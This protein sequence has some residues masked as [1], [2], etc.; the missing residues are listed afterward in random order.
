[1]ISQV[2]IMNPQAFINIFGCVPNFGNSELMEVKIRR[3]GPSL[4]IR[5]L[6]KEMVKVK[7]KRWNKCKSWSL[8]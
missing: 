7:P 2:R 8:Q 5:L 3:D 1:M 6:T 4:F